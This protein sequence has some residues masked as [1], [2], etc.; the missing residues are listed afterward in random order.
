MFNSRKIILDKPLWERIAKVAAQA[1]YASV[2]EFVVHV[3][4]KQVRDLEE[5]KDEEEVRK[6]LEGLGYID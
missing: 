2:P 6:R 1:G 4:E 3:L 5:G